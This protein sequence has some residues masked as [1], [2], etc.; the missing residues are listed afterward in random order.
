[1][2]LLALI[3][4]V[5]ILAKKSKETVIYMAGSSGNEGKKEEIKG[6]TYTGKLNMYVIQTQT[7]QDIAPQT[8]RL[9]GRQNI[10]ITLNQILSSCGIK[11][12]KIGAEDISFYA[13]PDKSLIVMDQSEKCTVLR[14][15]EI[16]KKGMGYPVYYN[17]KLTVTF[18][19]GITEM[20]IHYKNLK[21]SEQQSI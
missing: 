4:I 1:M 14:G 18:E 19:D 15:T 16:L 13:G 2:L 21:P 5:I 3:V 12:G 9:F 10:R 7:G 11:F 17:G 8:Y 6:C 20:E